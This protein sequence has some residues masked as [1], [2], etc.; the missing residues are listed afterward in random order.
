MRWKNETR[1]N[2]TGIAAKKCIPWEITMTIVGF[3]GNDSE[4]WGPGTGNNP[5]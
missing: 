2:E 1:C 3:Y 4:Y 5:V